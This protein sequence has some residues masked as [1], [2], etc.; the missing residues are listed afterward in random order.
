MKLSE[1]ILKQ[2]EKIEVILLVGKEQL[3]CMLS[4]R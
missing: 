4:Y 1:T 2:D 3:P